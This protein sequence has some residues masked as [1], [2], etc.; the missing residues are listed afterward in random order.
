M[1]P[2]DFGLQMAVVIAIDAVPVKLSAVVKHLAEQD[3]I[4]WLSTTIGRSDIISLA[5]F[6]SSDELADFLSKKLV[7]IEGVKDSET[8]ICLDVQKG[9]YV[10]LT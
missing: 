4:K 8:F 9:P 2:A 3:E 5:R 1:D 7:Q 10:P 6:S